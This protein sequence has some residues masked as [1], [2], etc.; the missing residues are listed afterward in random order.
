MRMRG[1]YFAAIC[2][3]FC[4]QIESVWSQSCWKYTPVPCE[5][6]A[7]CVD[8]D[9]NFSVIGYGEPL[10]PQFQPYLLMPITEY[11]CPDGTQGAWDIGSDRFVSACGESSGAMGYPTRGMAY[12]YLCHRTRYCS[13]SC[14]TTTQP[15]PMKNAV[16][17]LKP[18]A[19][20]I[21]TRIQPFSPGG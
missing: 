11:T 6:Y 20:S 12:T 15:D 5:T 2:F 21:A 14:T 13:R 8:A 16:Y 7:V 9:C 18:N 4:I 1:N 17:I 19:L 10:F 3:A